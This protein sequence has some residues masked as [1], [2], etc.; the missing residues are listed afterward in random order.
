M[1]GHLQAAHLPVDTALPSAQGVWCFVL[2]RHPIAIPRA[3]QAQ[4]TICAVNMIGQE[5]QPEG[6]PSGHI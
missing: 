4:L 2:Q 3:V 6:I 1:V 5:K